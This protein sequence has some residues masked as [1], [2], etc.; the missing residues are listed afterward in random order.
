M[1]AIGPTASPSIQHPSPAGNMDRARAL[2]YNRLEMARRILEGNPR[3]NRAWNIFIAVVDAVSS[4][5]LERMV[6]SRRRSSQGEGPSSP[7]ASAES[8]KPATRARTI[9][10]VETAGPDVR[11]PQ[12][13][14]ETVARQRPVPARTVLEEKARTL[15]VKVHAGEMTHDQAVEE[16]RQ[17]AMPPPAQTVAPATLKGPSTEETVADLRHRL[18][19]ELYRLELDLLTG[20]RIAGRPCDCFSKHAFGLE[21]LAEELMSMDRDPV[22]GEVIAWLREREPEFTPAAI[23]QTE[24]SYYQGLAPTVRGFRKRVLGASA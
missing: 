15:A 8:S 2:S 7:A 1:L 12:S 21:A 14:E 17:A 19:K 6:F 23:A 11:E 13:N 10:Q 5:P 4:M 18:A 3:V 22:Y 16:L 20:G 9:E 24:A